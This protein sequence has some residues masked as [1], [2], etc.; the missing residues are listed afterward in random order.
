MSIVKESSEIRKRLLSPYL[1]R[2]PPKVLKA[3]RA[4]NLSQ[5]DI[6][7][8]SGLSA[9]YVSQCLK[10]GDDNKRKVNV[11]IIAGLILGIEDGGKKP[12]VEFYRW[13]LL[14][15]VDDVDESVLYLIPGLSHKQIHPVSEQA[16]EYSSTINAELL[17][18]DANG[19]RCI[20]K[21]CQHHKYCNY[22]M[23]S[24]KAML[25]SNFSLNQPPARNSAEPKIAA[26]T[27]EVEQLRQQVED[28]ESRLRATETQARLLAAA[29]KSR[30][31][32]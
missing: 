23:E 10:G 15:K 26:L 6:R 11:D 8:H 22:K 3:M 4:H 21:T 9:T 17:D 2:L 28:M 29:F 32:A 5:A 25:G 1:S 31:A 12:T 20:G 27:A 13:L 19:F 24:C 14:G 16:G 30:A 18:M 7:R